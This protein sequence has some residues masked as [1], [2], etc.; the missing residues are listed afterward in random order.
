MGKYEDQV[1]KNAYEYH[2][3]KCNEEE[4]DNFQNEI[5]NL[6]MELDILKNPVYCEKCG[7]CGEEGCCSPG[8]C[9]TVQGLYCE[10]NVNSWEDMNAEVDKYYQLKTK[11]KEYLS[12]PSCDGHPSRKQ[13]RK[14]LQELIDV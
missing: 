14:D 11:L 9:K 1:D 10:G 5:D 7:S 6:K 2:T 13:L 12:H 8:K 3:K 4:I